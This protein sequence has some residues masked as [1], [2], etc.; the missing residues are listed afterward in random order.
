MCEKFCNQFD[1]SEHAISHA[2]RLVSLD[3][4]VKVHSLVIH[5]IVTIRTLKLFLALVEQTR[6]KS[7]FFNWINL[8]LKF[9]HLSFDN[10]AM[11]KLRILLLEE[12][13]LE[14]LVQDDPHETPQIIWTAA[15]ATMSERK[16]ESTNV[17][18]QCLLWQT[19][20]RLRAAGGDLGRFV[21]RP[22]PLSSP[23]R[24]ADTE[25]KKLLPKYT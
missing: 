5:L 10:N 24:T 25:A 15:R 22:C 14:C 2:R 3:S 11:T 20:L 17:R 8:I 6:L 23:P 7:Y 16:S 18:G 4:S 13:L 1:V 12:T 9:F 19:G 21:L